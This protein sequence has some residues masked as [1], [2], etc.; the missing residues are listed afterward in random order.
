MRYVITVE[1]KTY[2]IEVGR[3]GRVW[4]NRRPYDV[5]LQ[6]INGLPQYSLLVDHRSY[7]AHV[8]HSEGEECHMVVDGRSYRA[9]LHQA[10]TSSKPD[11]EAM[12]ERSQVAGEVCAPLPGL[13]VNVPVVVGQRIEHGEVVAVLESMKMNLEL[14]APCDGV[15]RAVYGTPGMEV[16]QGE[17]VVSIE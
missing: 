13:L 7:E 10:R 11:E 9:R 17:V 12:E 8:E 3:H 2:E 5:D 1:G 14:R 15:V 4:I 16:G 6:G